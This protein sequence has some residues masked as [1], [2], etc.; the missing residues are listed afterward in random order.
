MRAK[1]LLG[2][3][4][5]GVATMSA[6]VSHAAEPAARPAPAFTLELLNGK[7]LQLAD[8]KGSSHS[9]VLGSVVTDLSGRG[10]RVGAP[11]QPVEGQGSGVR[12]HRFAGQ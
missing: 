2:A 11:V 6:T 12:R 3:I 1:I 4:L 9:A 5:V 8:L 7:T 10:P